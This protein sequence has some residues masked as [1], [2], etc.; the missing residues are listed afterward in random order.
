MTT[1]ANFHRDEFACKCGCNTNEIQDELIDV[2]QEIRSTSGVKMIVSSG[3]RCPQHPD[4][5]VKA[6][7]GA[8]TEGTEAD[9]R[10]RGE[11]A[12]KVV[13]AAFAHS[14]ITAIGVK[15]IGGK[16]YIHLG[17]GKAKTGRPRPRLWSY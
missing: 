6:R 15:Q 3:Y 13:K 17:I 12:W 7:P 14:K 8:H 1:W 5:I 2:L 9:I 11:K 16:R 10:V 4:E